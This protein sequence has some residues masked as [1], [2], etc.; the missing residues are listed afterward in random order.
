MFDSV[1]TI[2][3]LSKI[4]ILCAL[5]SFSPKLEAHENYISEAVSDFYRG[6]DYGVWDYSLSSLKVGT[7]LA[8]SSLVLRGNIRFVGPPSFT[9]ATFIPNYE[10]IEFR[11][12]YQNVISLPALLFPVLGYPLFVLSSAV[13][14][15]SYLA[16]NELTALNLFFTDQ[17]YGGFAYK[18]YSGESLAYTTGMQM[19]HHL[20]CTCTS[21][22]PLFLIERLIKSL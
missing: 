12:I 4:L 19:G 15:G 22:I 18:Y 3:Y 7:V 11:L 20:F 16:T 13:H 10:E 2:G 5:L 21:S 9:D 6:F 8:L 14:A 1:K 17:I